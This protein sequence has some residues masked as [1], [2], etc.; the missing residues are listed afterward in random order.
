MIVS[1]AEAHMKLAEFVYNNCGN[2]SEQQ[3]K[4]AIARFETVREMLEHVNQLRGR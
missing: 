3:Q 4:D 2:L 1:L